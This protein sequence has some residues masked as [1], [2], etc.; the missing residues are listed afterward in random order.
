[1]VTLQPTTML[2]T[3][4][5]AELMTV[6]E[7]AKEAGLAM[8]PAYDRV[9][10]GRWPSCLVGRQVL[11]P[12]SAFLAVLAHEAREKGAKQAVEGRPLPPLPP[13]P[14]VPD[15]PPAPAVARPPAGPHLL[16]EIPEVLAQ[17]TRLVTHAE[18]GEWA[19]VQGRL[20]SLRQRLQV[21]TYHAQLAAIHAALG[22]ASDDDETTTIDTAADHTKPV[23]VDGPCAGAA[24]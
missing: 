15:R 9:R 14:P 13:V 10:D 8:T 20:D 17:I 18:R 23:A 22:Q 4:P 11:V 24:A 3:L 16:R 5:V 7:A 21:L 1:M 19:A 2:I 6:A 12:R